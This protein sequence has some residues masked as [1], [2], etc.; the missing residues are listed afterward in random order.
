MVFQHNCTQVFLLIR[1]GVGLLFSFSLR[2]LQYTYTITIWT[3]DKLLD[4]NKNDWLIDD[5]Y[6]EFFSVTFQCLNRMRVFVQSL[7]PNTVR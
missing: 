4:L 2:Q 5:K 6:F 3:F 7:G 1:I